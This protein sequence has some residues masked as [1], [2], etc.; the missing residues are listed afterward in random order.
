MYARPIPGETDEDLLAQQEEFLKKFKENKIQ[1]A[2]KIV[3]SEKETILSK[4]TICDNIQAIENDIQDQLANTF[5]SIPRDVDIGRIIEKRKID[6]NSSAGS[7]AFNK[8]YGFPKAKRRDVT[9]K[10]SSG[11]IFS[12]QMRQKVQGNSSKLGS[13]LSSTN[14]NL[15][16]DV[17]AMDMDVENDSNL[18][19]GNLVKGSKILS[20]ADKDEIHLKN[21]DVL[22]TMPESEI[23]EEKERLLSTMDPAIISFLKA[24]R[25]EQIPKSS[26]PSITK[27]NEAGHNINIDKLM[28]TAEILDNPDA[29][30]WLNFDL[31]ETHKLAWMKE[32]EVAKIDKSRAF[33]ARFDF[34]GWLLPF[35]ET[36]INEKNRILYH[37]GEEPDRPGYTLQEL[38]TLARSSVIQ[39]KTIALNSIANILSLHSTGVYQDILEIPI[40]QLFFLI[41]FCMDDNTPG[42]LNASVKAMWH[43]IC[44]YIDEIC[45]DCSLGFGWNNVIPILPVDYEKK[46]I[47]P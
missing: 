41:R 27:Q 45:L 17:V 24:R 3:P 5:E 9:V 12:Q 39:Q 23:L 26:N 33:E 21:I 34:Q 36:E 42:P 46:M 29:E 25:R 8:N 47:I 13:F 7:L 22:K 10:T 16:K 19:I 44:N 32:I 4:D 18:K 20:D 37:H 6:D 28:A 35:T 40:E 1:L 2:A 38:F 15:D 31:L 30:K 14:N 43:L 11:S